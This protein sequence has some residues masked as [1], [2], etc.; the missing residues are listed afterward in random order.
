M[1]NLGKTALIRNLTDAIRKG[2]WSDRQIKVMV[3]SLWR[4]PFSS[5]TSGF[6]LPGGTDAEISFDDLTRTFTIQPA[7]FDDPETPGIKFAFY[8]LTTS[9]KLHKR[10][11]SE[12]LL[13]PDEEGLFVIH[14]AQNEETLVWELTYAKDPTYSEMAKL[15]LTGVI[16]AWIYWDQENQEAVYFGDE[17]HGS[18]WNPPI[19]WW[20]H[21]AFNALWKSGFEI[22]NLLIGDGSLTEHAQFGIA[23]GEFYHEDIEQAVEA[24]LPTTGLPVLWFDGN[25]PRIELNPGYSFLKGTNF[26]YYNPGG[27]LVECSDEAFCIYHVFATN[28]QIHPLISVMGY[29]LYNNKNA[30]CKAALEEI[31]ILKKKIPHQTSLPIAS[32][33]FEANSLFTNDPKARIVEPCSGASCFLWIEEVYNWFDIQIQIEALEIVNNYIENNYSEIINIINNY[34]TEITNIFT[35]DGQTT[36]ITLNNKPNEYTLRVYLNGVRQHPNDYSVVDTTVTF[37]DPPLWGDII[38]VFYEPYKPSQEIG[39]EV[40]TGSIDGS[41]AEF[42]LSETPDP[43]SVNVYLNGIL[44]TSSAY[45]VNGDVVTLNQAPL[46]GDYIIIDYK[47]DSAPENAAFNQSPTG[48]VNGSNMVYTLPVSAERVMVYLNGVRQLEDT[49]FTHTGDTITFSAAPQSGDW[50]LVDFEL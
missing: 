4:D 1:S 5:R 50:I 25:N 40:P 36:E 19:H 16:V 22:T 6:D 13:I 43:G 35:G 29:N 14:Y 7:N 37:N 31:Q 33:V 38:Q 10:Y 26:I 28:C 49:H 17:R 12:S 32:F 39:G 44:Q 23:E 45:I 11:T 20:A 21:G 3:E 8:T 30:A 27:T 34:N 41:N 9:L 18:E 24:S 42:T 46:D 15:Y 2:G 48:L 47:T